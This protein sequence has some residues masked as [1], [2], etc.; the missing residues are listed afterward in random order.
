MS[1]TGQVGGVRLSGG[2]RLHA[3]AEAEVEVEYAT[4]AA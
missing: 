1:Q 3:G 2:G 4:Y